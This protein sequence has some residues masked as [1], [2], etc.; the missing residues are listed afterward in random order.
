MEIKAMRILC[1]SCQH[2]MKILTSKQISSQYRELFCDCESLTC[3]ARAVMNVTLSHYTRPPESDYKK[4]I[5]NYIANL[6]PSERR[7]IL[8]DLEESNIEAGSLN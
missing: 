2:T 6:T 4:M 8:L 1:P 7:Q 5:S 3:G